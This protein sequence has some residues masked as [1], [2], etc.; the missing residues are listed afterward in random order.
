MTATR[1]IGV[2]CAATLVLGCPP[3]QQR[4]PD[5]RNGQA[6]APPGAQAEFDRAFDLFAQS[7]W[8]DAEKAFAEVLQ[9]YPTSSLAGE[10]RYRRGVALN[11]LDRYEE[12]RTALRE[13]LEKNPT[14][15][16]ARQASVE[17]GL[18]EAKL[19]NKQDAEQILRPVVGDLTAEERKEVGVALDEAVKE[20]SAPLEALR[21]AAANAD[22]SSGSEREAALDELAKLLDEKAGF[23][24]VVQLA[25]LLK[26]KGP[27]APVVDAKLSR[28]YY[29]LG[30]FDRAREAAERALAGGVTPRTAR[31]QVVL[32]RLALRDTVKPARIG[33]VL[34][35]SGRLKGV[36]EGIQDAIKLAISGKDGLEVVYK[37][38]RGE[39][40]D[41]ADAVEALVNEGAIV[42]I[43]AVSLGESGPAALRAQELGVPL[44]SLS[45]AEGL[46][47]IGDYVF[48]NSL[49]NSAQGKA[50]ARYASEVLGVK[51]AAIL[52][53]DIP[54]GDEAAG[55]FW[56]SFEQDGG[57][58]RGFETYEHDQTT[59]A[60]PIKKLVARENLA[61][62]EE[63]RAE[64][65]RIAQ[66]EKNPY[67]RR[68][69]MEQLAGKQPPVVDFDALLIPDWH[70]EVSMI[71]PAL[72]VEDVITT[73]CDE[74]ELERIK[75]T[76]KRTDIRPV[77]LLGTNGWNDPQLV[78]RG[79]RFV[80]CAVF[81]DGFFAG[82]KREAT[83]RFVEDWNEEYAPRKPGLF[84]ALGY[85][86]ARIVR[87]V[88]MRTKP[89]SRVE[90]RDA[91][92][93]VKKFQGATGETSFGPDREADKPLFFLTVDRTG[94]VE[95]D[96]VKISPNGPPTKAA[97][98]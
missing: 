41:A 7:K 23:V 67:K 55:A 32:Q 75:K 81:V 28:I 3:Q 6:P 29:H 61:D 36:G 26:G 58:I 49:T 53:P 79:G 38:S 68:R 77:T 42:I 2:I 15:P 72:A 98:K 57:E 10:A 47:A 65:Q 21:R 84:E 8:A 45:R 14:S 85:D 54:S 34:P 48:R 19:G 27:A 40:A 69:L 43:G 56:E 60:R 83:A 93:R 16:Y 66:T 62:R 9:R 20:G 4:R 78:T 52:Q 44:V 25:E 92:A 89:K 35:L 94:I 87:D 46:P 86:T 64:A 17:L 13:F 33:V 73:G 37:D 74:K 22:K 18:A 71:A 96:G 50:L 88:A 76:T 39:P 59:F 12:G 1:L 82:S 11:R 51:S 5:T 80:Q 30:D 70:K 31:A 91:L 24:D 90:F 63:F 97:A 95:L